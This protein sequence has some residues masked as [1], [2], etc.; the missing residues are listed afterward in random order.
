M[1]VSGQ[2]PRGQST[3]SSRSALTRSAPR[4]APSVN[5]EK[6]FKPDPSA[7]RS[8]FARNLAWGAGAHAR[9]MCAQTRAAGT[10][11]DAANRANRPTER[12]GANLAEIV[13]FE[14]DGGSVPAWL[15]PSLL[16]LASTES[17]PKCVP[18]HVQARPH[19][20][21]LARTWAERAGIGDHRRCCTDDC[22]GSSQIHDLIIRNA[23]IVDGTGAPPRSGDVT[24]DSGKITNVSPPG[25]VTAKATRI[26]SA[27]E[28]LDFGTMEF[29]SDSLNQ[30]R[31]WRGSSTSRVP[32]A[33]RSRAHERHGRGAHVRARD[34]RLVAAHAQA[35]GGVDPREVMMDTLAD[36][37]P[38]LVLFGRYEGT[39]KG[40]GRSSSIR[41]ACSAC[42]TAAPT[43]A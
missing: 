18:C 19:G 3:L 15:G 25:A 33:A 38:L 11:N 23:T 26:G 12:I 5:L 41:R 10:S 22:P 24:V 17:S 1:A 14:V 37:Q 6:V 7:G 20:A 27:F 29:V 31:S 16:A 35:R 42:P 34:R 13:H 2:G 8:P 30:P 39:S 28:G 36:G 9:L 43:A 21:G 4:L 40:S 32:R